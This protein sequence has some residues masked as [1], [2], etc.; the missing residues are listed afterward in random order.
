MELDSIIGLIEQIGV[1]IVCLGACGWYIRYLSDQFQCER[2][3]MREQE[4]Q[5]D[6]QLI[7]LVKASS[8]ALVELKTALAEQTITM[9][10]LLGKLD[11]RR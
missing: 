10:E 2:H 8:D 1:P 3:E 5:N 9:R 7:E 4:L 6:S 11:K